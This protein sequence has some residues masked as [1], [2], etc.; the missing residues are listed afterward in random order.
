MRIIVILLLVALTTSCAMIDDLIS[1]VE[2]GSLALDRAAD[3]LGSDSTKWRDTIE[4]GMKQLPKD[5]QS[6]IRVEVDNAV[7][8]AVAATG[9]E[10][11]C[12]TDFIRERLKRQIHRISAALRGEVLSGPVPEFC[13]V[14]PP[15]I[16][17]NLAEERRQSV[18]FVG[19][20]LDAVGQ[21]GKSL[22]FQLSDDKSGKVV[23][24]ESGRVGTATHYMV[25]IRLT[26]DEL[27]RSV[28]KHG[29]TKLQTV[30][31]GRILPV[32]EA[33]LV[34][35]VPKTETRT[36]PIGIKTYVPTHVEGDGDFDT[37]DDEHMSYSV[38]GETTFNDRQ[39][40]VRVRMRA[41]EERSDWTTVDGT[42]AWETAYTAPM[43]YKI[44]GVTPI[45]NSNSSS[46]INSWGAHEYK[47]PAGEVVTRFEV[48]GDHDGDDAGSYTRV[49]AYFADVSVKIEEILD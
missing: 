9:A 14:T 34:V 22:A 18:I 29:V 42:S 41:R 31:N 17:F 11:R 44:I 10:F 19:Y 25:S 23:P 49:V 46:N 1:R 37:D 6:T 35:R 38:S 16:D 40:L 4:Q 12:N 5:V 24:I 3:Q 33:L 2:R 30:W 7:G 8:R 48:Y 20:D 13:S 43:G 15:L 32:G 21:D 27:E 47:L 39:I 26:G 28:R 36:V 45:G